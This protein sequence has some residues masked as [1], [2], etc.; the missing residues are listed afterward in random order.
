MKILI[1][2]LVMVAGLWGSCDLNQEC[3]KC[4]APTLVQPV[5]QVITQTIVSREAYTEYVVIPAVWTEKPYDYQASPTLWSMSDC[6]VVQSTCGD[7]N[8]TIQYYLAEPSRVEEVEHAEETID[9][10][11]YTETVPA[12][13]TYEERGCNP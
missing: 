2:S 3:G 6:G 7:S 10:L 12:S 13:V 11:V 5:V 4:Y 1:A 9:I 8:V